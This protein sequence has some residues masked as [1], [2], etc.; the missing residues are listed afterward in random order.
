M[1]I[2]KPMDR[3]VATVE[4]CIALRDAALGRLSRQ[5][6]TGVALTLSLPKKRFAL[7]QRIGDQFRFERAAVSPFT[8]ITCH[9]SPLA[10]FSDSRSTISRVINSFSK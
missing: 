8:L 1:R 10:S 9:F 2:V 4:S 5:H 6:M 7:R 3:S